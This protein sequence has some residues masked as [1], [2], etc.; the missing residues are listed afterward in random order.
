M[1]VA[2]DAKLAGAVGK[3]LVSGEHTV[4]LAL[5]GEE[6]FLLAQTQTFDLLVIDVILPGRDGIEILGHIR[7]L[8]NRTPVLLLSSQA[9]I[10]DRVR[11]LDA[12][13]DDYLVRPFALPELQARVRALVRRSKPDEDGVLRLGDL[14]MD[15]IRH[16]ATREGKALDATEREFELLEYF[17]RQPGR[18]VYARHAGARRVE[19][20]GAPCAG[21]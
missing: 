9:A 21:G 1:I 19:G 10:E 8:G 2:D 3:G 13:A 4:S 18:V 15:R 7:S 17:L 5:T 20:T 11:G 6:G 16:C 14:E 12:G